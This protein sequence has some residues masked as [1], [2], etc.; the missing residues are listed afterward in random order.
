MLRKLAICVECPQHIERPD[1]VARMEYPV[2]V[3]QLPLLAM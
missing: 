1:C 3:L 2:H